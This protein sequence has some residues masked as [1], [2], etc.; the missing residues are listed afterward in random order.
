MALSLETLKKCRLLLLSDKREWERAA[1]RAPKKASA[2]RLGMNLAAKDVAGML[3]E[4][5]AEIA[6]REKE[7]QP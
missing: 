2:Y 1:E 6:E 5:E 3:A 4:V 7:V